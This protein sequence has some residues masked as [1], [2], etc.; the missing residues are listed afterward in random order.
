MASPND[1][2]IK[3][4]KKTYRFI[5]DGD[6]AAV[7]GKDGITHTLA[8]TKYGQGRVL[9]TVVDENG[10]EFRLQ[11]MPRPCSCKGYPWSTSYA[12]LKGQL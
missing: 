6:K 10:E 7:Y 5:S 3:V 11:R 1:F 9:P 4:D 8:V 2:P 12:E